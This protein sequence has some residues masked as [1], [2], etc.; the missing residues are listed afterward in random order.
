MPINIEYAKKIRNEHK[1]PLTIL[2]DTKGPE[3]RTANQKT[4]SFPAKTIISLV[5]EK[6]G[7]N[8][9]CKNSTFIF[10]FRFQFPSPFSPHYPPKPP[11]LEPH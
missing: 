2:L 9:N 7:K 8:H 4:V 11:Q 10:Q 3:I 5:K 6:T 1:K